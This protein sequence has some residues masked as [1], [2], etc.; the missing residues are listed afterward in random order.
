[1]PPGCTAQVCP[2][3]SCGRLSVTVC[4]LFISPSVAH[5]WCRET[6][7]E[8]NSGICAPRG[9][10]SVGPDAP[11]LC[12]E[13]S[14]DYLAPEGFPQVEG[15]VMLPRNVDVRWDC[16]CLARL[17]LDM[18]FPAASPWTDA[19]TLR[20]LQIDAVPGHVAAGVRARCGAYSECGAGSNEPQPK[21]ATHHLQTR[22]R[23]TTPFRAAIGQGRSGL[24]QR[25]RSMLTGLD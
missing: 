7:P 9:H 12:W 22:W 18:F 11:Q 19:E 20:S 25:V 8:K 2:A 17:A 3:G 14:L 21:K 13:G 24:S 6:D 23:A 5:S 15:P 16:W 10:E 4:S 1:M